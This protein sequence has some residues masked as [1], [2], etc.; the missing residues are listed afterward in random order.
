VNAREKPEVQ[1]RNVDDSSFGSFRTVAIQDYA[2]QCV[3]AGRWT[4]GDAV[5][6]STDELEKLLVDGWRTARHCIAEIMHR[7]SGAGFI[8][9]GPDPSRED[10]AFI[11]MLYL[12]EQC[13]GQGLG[14]AA[15]EAAEVRI[16]KQGYR[17]VGLHT[18]TSN[19][20]AIRLYQSRGFVTTDVVMVKELS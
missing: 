6:K 13:R 7:G 11:Y 8:W 5:Q 18:F 20:Q 12:H 2:Q 15:M 16:A 17:D 3:R 9:W 14:A 4:A 19:E 10:R 1:L